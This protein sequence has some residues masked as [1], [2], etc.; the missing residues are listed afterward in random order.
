MAGGAGERFWPLSRRDRPKQLLRLARLDQSMLEEAVERVAPLIGRERV[1]VATARHLVEPIRRAMPALPAENVIGEPC[2][3]NTAGC[4]AWAAAVARSRFAG[5]GRPVSMAVLTADHQIGQPERFRATVNAALTAAEQK[6]ALVTIGDVPTRPETG[7]GYIEIPEG[8]AAI[9]IDGAATDAPP[10]YPV[11]RFREKPN[12]EAARAFVAS[13]RF[14]WNS[15]MFFWTLDAFLGE[16][17]TAAPAHGQAA[18]EMGEALAIGD[19]ARAEA[20]FATL[21]DVSIDYA[22]MEKA[23]NVL[24][25]RADFPWDDVGALDALARNLPADAAGNVAVGDPVL[26]DARDCIVYNEPGAAA[27][28]VGVAGVKGLAVVVTRDGVL[29]LPRDRAQDVK[30]V[31]A[32]LKARGATQL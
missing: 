30:K 9:A 15:G 23:K 17:A 6:G 31:V 10:V 13:G 28:A 11:A 24:V 25:V 22:L 8:A 26:V 29:V 1:L 27:M 2:K 7:Y 20:I 5:E 18:R 3:R 21:E 12:A 19:A 14:Y 32:E 4:L 16:L